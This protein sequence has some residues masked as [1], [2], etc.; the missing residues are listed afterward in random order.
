[1][2]RYTLKTFYG[3]KQIER[4]EHRTKDRLRG[5][6]NHPKHHRAGQTGPWGEIEKHADRFEVFD[7]LN[8]KIF[9]GNIAETI[10]FVR[11]LR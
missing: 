9:T 7:S 2:A 11:K 3:T 10:A 1:M 8:E 4:F 6:L 5:I